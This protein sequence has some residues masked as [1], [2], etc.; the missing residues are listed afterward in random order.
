[1]KN[2]T[3]IT[4]STHFRELTQKTFPGLN[5][6]PKYWRFLRYLVF[7][8][9][10]DRDANNQ[11]LV[12][13][14]G[15][16]C[17]LAEKD[18]ANYSAENFLTAFQRDVMTEDTFQWSEHDALKG[19]ARTVKL[20]KFPAEFDKALQA[21]LKN[22]WRNLGRVYFCDGT[23]FSA[24]KQRKER[25]REKNFVNQERHK[26]YSKEGQEIK[27]YM[28]GL[29][30]NLFTKIVEKNFAAAQMEADAIA[31]SKVR[32]IQLIY[33]HR[34]F[35]QPQPFYAASANTD[36][37]FGLGGSIPSLQKDVRRALTSGWDEADLK[38]AQLAICASLWK[39]DEINEYLT[40]GQS[41]WEHLF[42]F[43]PVPTSQQKIVKPILKNALYSLCYG[44]KVSNIK[45]EI[46]KKL[47]FHG[48][49]MRGEQF[50]Q[51]DLMQILERGREKELARIE[52]NGA[53]T[54]FGKK[55]I[56]T[57]TI[58]ARKIL[59]QI[60]QAVEVKLMS[61]VIRFASKTDEFKVTLWQHDGFCAK[62]KRSE[63]SEPWKKKISDVVNGAAAENG[64]IT[65]LEWK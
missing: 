18:P 42:E 17:A 52:S 10:F 26:P 32:K 53:T 3:R 12:I 37:I 56:I 58:T 38:N 60:A 4:T 1:M 50:F 41:I 64:I 29:S 36:R 49:Q 28:N 13:D 54:C 25:N 65:Y 46:S 40:T 16:I 63:Y 21:E 43:F 24:A 33:L 7:G 30:V 47:K 59:A 44:M 8:T 5:R 34:I 22:T 48:I 51:S 61:H 11:N 19:R 45:G 31:D 2:L 9:F 20:L 23:K 15:T 62:F 14:K 35:D 55:L 6:N 27:D 39:I 57:K